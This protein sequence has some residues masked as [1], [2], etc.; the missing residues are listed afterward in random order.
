MYPIL[1]FL[2]LATLLLYINFFF[3]FFYKDSLGG[4]DANHPTKAG[5]SPV[6]QRARTRD[7]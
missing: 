7:L 4:F 2:L 3:F 1:N 5:H 6:A